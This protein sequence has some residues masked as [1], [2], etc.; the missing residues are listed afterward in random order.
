[1][2]SQN[3]SGIQSIKIQSSANV[4]IYKGDSVSVKITGDDAAKVKVDQSGVELAIAY[5]DNSSD[6][7]FTMFN[8]MSVGGSVSI[9]NIRQN[10]TVITGSGNVFSGVNNAT[11]HTNGGKQI[12]IVGGE[13]FINGVRVDVPEPS[14]DEKKYTPVEVEIWCPDGLAI[15]CKLDGEAIFNAIPQFDRARITIS[16]SCSARLQAKSP[17]LNVSGSGNIECKSLGGILN[18]KVD[19]S[20][21]ITVDGE[22]HSVEVDISGSGKIKTSGAVGGDYEVNVS[23]MGDVIHRGTIAGRKSKSISGMGS[24][25]W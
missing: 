13:V 1:M 15:D 10:N 4:T 8:N 23:G 9:G 20:G 17:R 3:Y 12:R 2:I 14:P 21:D 6:G 24:V 25:R 22:F 18:A 5:A 19:G 11:I 16:G 7:N